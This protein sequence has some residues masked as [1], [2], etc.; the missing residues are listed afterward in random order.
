[1]ADCMAADEAAI[2][3]VA[4]ERQMNFYGSRTDTE[5]REAVPSVTSHS[6]PCF[7]V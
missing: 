7:L 6:A 5:K 3:R 4:F 2:H 1:M